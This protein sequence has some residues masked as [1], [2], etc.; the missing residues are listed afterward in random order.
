[1]TVEPKQRGI[2][3]KI[4]SLKPVLKTTQG[5]QWVFF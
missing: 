3:Q 4:E 5:E 2:A 1:L